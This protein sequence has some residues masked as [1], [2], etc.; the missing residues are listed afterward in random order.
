MVKKRE[1]VIKALDSFDIEIEDIIT[2]IED[3]HN[4]DIFSEEFNKILLK[5]KEEN[6]DSE[7]LLNITSGT[8]QM[9]S[10]LCLE[11]VT[12][13]FRLKPI[14]VITPIKGSNEGVKFGGDIE[15]NFDSLMED[16]KYITPNR[17]IEPNILSFRRNSVKRDIISLVE[18]FEYRAAAEKLENNQYLFNDNALSLIKYAELRQNDNEEYRGSK[19]NEWNDEFDYTKD[20]NAKLACDYYCILK[21]KGKTG[22]LSYFVLLL[23][24][25]AEHIAKHY[26]GNFTDNEVIDVLNNYYQEKNKTNYKPSIYKGKVV[27]NLEQYICIMTYKNKPDTIIEK[28]REV[29]PFI[30]SRNDLAHFLY[31]EDTI[32]PNRALAL[33]KE[34]LI[35]V[36]GNKVKKNSLKL[37]EKINERIIQLL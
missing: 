29:L 14:Q 24:P 25:L 15:N 32:N 9:S 13:Y 36:Y 19:W 2:D 23:K 30:N 18:H 37:Y 22:E 28:F 31:R 5:I 35:C 10:A 16:G 6:N 21:N 12:S 27:Y 7:I 1:D 8:T 26:I 20:L 3:P 17:C 34:L 4:F 33:I 11:V